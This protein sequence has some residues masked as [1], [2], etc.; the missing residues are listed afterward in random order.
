MP[1]IWKLR[2]LKFRL[3]HLNLRPMWL[4]IRVRIRRSS[5]T[6]SA[7]CYWQIRQRH[8]KLTAACGCILTWNIDQIYTTIMIHHDP[9]WVIMYPLGMP[10]DLWAFGLKSFDVP[11]DAFSGRG[12]GIFWGPLVWP[13]VNVP[14]SDCRILDDRLKSPKAS[15]N[16]R[17]GTILVESAIWHTDGQHFQC[18]SSSSLVETSLCNGSSANT[19]QDWQDMYFLQRK[20]TG[21]VTCLWLESQVSQKH[22]P[23]PGNLLCVKYMFLLRLTSKNMPFFIAESQHFGKLPKAFHWR[24]RIEA[25]QLSTLRGGLG[26]AFQQIGSHSLTDSFCLHRLSNPLEGN[27]TNTSLFNLTLQDEQC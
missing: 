15:T 3:K 24:W 12:R 14:P 26:I 18:S 1:Q 2:D 9:A 17:L 16:S 11:Q 13:T 21:K 25:I 6:F 20:I 8:C 10:L 7:V 22:W 27:Q 19:R 23:I 4:I 5:D